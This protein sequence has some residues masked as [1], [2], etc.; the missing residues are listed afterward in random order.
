MAV[1]SELC[2]SCLSEKR[3][4]REGILFLNEPEC[5]VPSSLILE[6]CRESTIESS[7]WS[8]TLFSPMQKTSLFQGLRENCKVQSVC[9]VLCYSSGPPSLSK[10]SVG[11][12]GGMYHLYFFEM[13]HK[14]VVWGSLQKQ[15]ITCEQSREKK[16]R[17]FLQLKMDT[18][19]GKDVRHLE[20]R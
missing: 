19:P 3:A 17:A 4:V 1:H 6:S 13:L 7:Q 16:R 12:S 8:A 11:R 18:I 15:E 2:G 5:H 9:M 20:K 10:R 14:V